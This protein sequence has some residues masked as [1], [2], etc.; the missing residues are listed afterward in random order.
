MTKL[1]HTDIQVGLQEA[2]RQRAAEWEEV[3]KRFPIPEDATP[4]EE[5]S[6]LMQREAAMLDP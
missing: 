3:K 5:H 1:N 2:R 4:E 6:I